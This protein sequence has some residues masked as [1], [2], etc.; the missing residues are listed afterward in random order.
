MLAAID[1]RLGRG[2]CVPLKRPKHRRR[3]RRVAS[4]PV[5]VVWGRQQSTQSNEPGKPKDH[6]DHLDGRDDQPMRKVGKVHRGEGKIGSCKKRGPD[7]IEEHKID[8]VAAPEE[9]DDYRGD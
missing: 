3:L 5:A 1:R 7:A 4:A 9:A 6:G 8:G 2:R